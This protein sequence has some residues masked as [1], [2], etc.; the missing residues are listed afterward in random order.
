MGG[1]VWADPWMNWSWQAWEAAPR[2]DTGLEPGQG[3]IAV[4]PS[5]TM[6]SPGDPTV[7]ALHLSIGDSVRRLSLVVQQ[8]HRLT[9]SADLYGSEASGSTILS[10]G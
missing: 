5:A 10:R 8:A 3:R 2:A 9:Q 4:P 7:P 1:L 6:A